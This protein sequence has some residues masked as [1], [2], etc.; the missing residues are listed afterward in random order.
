MPPKKENPLP[1]G[2]ETEY[3]YPVSTRLD[4]ETFQAME[5]HRGKVGRSTWIRHLIEKFTNTEKE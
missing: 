2:A 5:K 3:K 4:K 1:Y